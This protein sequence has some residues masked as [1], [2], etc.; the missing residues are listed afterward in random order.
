MSRIVYCVNITLCFPCD[1]YCIQLHCTYCNI[2]VLTSTGNPVSLHTYSKE[3]AP[4]KEPQV[5]KI[6]SEPSTT[7]CLIIKTC[8]GTWNPRKKTMKTKME[9]TCLTMNFFMHYLED[10]FAMYT[11]N[12]LGRKLSMSLLSLL[13]FTCSMPRISYKWVWLFSMFYWK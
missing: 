11:A 3:G 9:P 2:K 7:M 10:V 8:F 5:V 12:V 6:N 13:Q 4:V 1:D